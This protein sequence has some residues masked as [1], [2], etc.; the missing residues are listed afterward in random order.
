MFSMPLTSSRKKARKIIERKSFSQLVGM[1]RPMATATA[2]VATPSSTKPHRHAESRPLLQGGKHHRADGHESGVEHVDAR[3]DAGAAVGAGPGLHG[4]EGRHN[5]QAAGDRKPRKIDHDVNPAWRRKE[6]GDAQRLA[7]CA[8]PDCANPWAVQPR[9]TEN[10]PSST[11]PASVWQD[12]DPSGRKPGGKA[13]ADRDSDRKNRQEHGDDGL[14]SAMS[15]PPA[16][17]A[18]T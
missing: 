5:E 4:G 13:G 12:D 14:G 2:R 7:G 18:T 8:N 1:V 6:T 16:A 15:T 11:A 17:T 3:Y 9:S 10:R